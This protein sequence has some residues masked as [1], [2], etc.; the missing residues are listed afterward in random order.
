M[1]EELR[2]ELNDKMNEMHRDA[3]RAMLRVNEL[4]V[5]LM[6]R[7]FA[8][9]Q[10][11]DRADSRINNCELLRM[12]LDCG[13]NLETGKFEV[14]KNLVKVTFDQDGNY[15]DAELVKEKDMKPIP[16]TMSFSQVGSPEKWEDK[17][18]GSCELEPKL[19]L[20]DAVE[21][22]IGTDTNTESETTP[23]PVEPI[24][25]GENVVFRVETDDG[26]EYL[27]G[28][29]KDSQMGNGQYAYTIDTDK[30]IYEDIEE[31]HI[32]VE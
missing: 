29:I 18:A 31:E 9:K 27:K 19:D 26:E 1:S 5:V 15:K 20:D 11:L 16:E 8:L 32:E 17:E 2:M 28:K 24:A 23:T 12:A 7:Y 14:H 3:F 6:E 22:E 21:D 30:R 25:N 13:F 4:P 10:Y